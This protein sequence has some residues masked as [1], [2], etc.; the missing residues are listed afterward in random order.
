MEALGNHAGFPWISDH[1]NMDIFRFLIYFS[2]RD[3]FAAMGTRLMLLLICIQRILGFR[4]SPPG[5]DLTMRMLPLTRPEVARLVPRRVTRSQLVSY[6]GMNSKERLQR[7]LESLLVSY[8]GAW[9]AWFVSFMVGSLTSAVLGSALIFNWMYT[10]WLNAKRR[11]ALFYPSS[12]RETPGSRGAHY[13]IFLGRIKTLK[14]VQR[15]AGKS[16]GAVS[17]EFLVLS[18]RD[19]YQRELEIVTQWQP[20]YSHLRINM[21]CQ[22]VI[23]SS[24]DAFAQVFLV[25]DAFVPACNLMVGDYP[26]LQK[27]ELQ[28]LLCEKYNPLDDMVMAVSDSLEGLN[29]RALFQDPPS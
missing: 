20:P 14:K 25:T 6:W 29:S 3:F 13:A 17:Q 22:T 24:D 27:Q 8:G 11:N 12:A 2:E 19:E 9:I 5:R 16:I 21:Q 1:R 15:R 28:Q 26:Y 10:P 4:S 18:V 7:V 23:A